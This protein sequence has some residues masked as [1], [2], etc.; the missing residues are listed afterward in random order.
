MDNGYTKQIRERIFSAEDGSV[1]AASDFALI[2]SALRSENR[3]FPPGKSGGGGT[4]RRR[5]ERN[6]VF[7]DSRT[8]REEGWSPGKARAVLFPANKILT[9][10]D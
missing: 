1:F 9:G 7:V 4:A 10:P 5:L 3:R 2:F 8:Y 6:V